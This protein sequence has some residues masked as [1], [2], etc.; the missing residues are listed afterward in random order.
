M[1]GHGIEVYSQG[2][3][4]DGHACY[5]EPVNA[6]FAEFIPAFRANRDAAVEKRTQEI[7]STPI[8]DEAWADELRRR[9]RLDRSFAA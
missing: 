6:L 2:V 7:A 8:D 9:A 1:A 5:W 3:I 4:A